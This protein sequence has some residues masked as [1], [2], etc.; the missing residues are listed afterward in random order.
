[1]DMSKKLI[2]MAAAAVLGW[3]GGALAQQTGLA[4]SGGRAA[5]GGQAAGG[6]LV[7]NVDK[8]IATIQP[9]M[10]G[11]FFEDINMAADGGVYA[12]LVKNRSFEFNNPL[13]GWTPHE[14]NGSSVKDLNKYEALNN[15]LVLNRGPES[16]DNPRYLRILQTDAAKPLGISNEGFRGM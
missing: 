16:P 4:V 15:F 14:K 6:D 7:V 8:P 13:Q 10:W 2:T 5:S 1:M 3:S 9:T 12:E 11:I